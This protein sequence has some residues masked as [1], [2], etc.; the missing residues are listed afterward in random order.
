MSN[1]A[2]NL[3]GNLSGENM[4]RVVVRQD[5]ALGGIV[6]HV[7]EYI[8]LDD[9]NLRRALDRGWAERAP[10]PATRDFSAPGALRVEIGDGGVKRI[11]SR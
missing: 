11:V 9:E 1:D 2:R 7:G 10:A 4:T 5:I 3:T 8:E 6:Y